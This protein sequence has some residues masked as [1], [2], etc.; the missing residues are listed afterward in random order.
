MPSN[1][2]RK[3]KRERKSPDKSATLCEEGTI[4]W[5]NNKERWVVKQSDTGTKRWIPY[6]SANLFGYA[7]LTAKVL[8][9]HINTPII[10]YERQS[11][12]LWPK[13]SKDFD[14]K[15]SFTASGDAE[16]YGKDKTSKIFTNWLKRKVPAVKQNDVFIVKGTLRSKDINSTLQVAPLPTELISTQLMNTDAFIR[17]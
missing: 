9:K 6:H 4:E 11:S 8:E 7:P 5:G 14:V 15:Y 13:S 12:Y 1:K 3:I 17:V 2:T 10:I 16:L